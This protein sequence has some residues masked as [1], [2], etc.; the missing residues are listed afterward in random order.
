MVTT[1]RQGT[2]WTARLAV[3]IPRDGGDDITSDATRR[4]Q[5][6]SAISSVELVE[7]HGIEPALAATITHLEIRISTAK[8]ISKEDVRN[9]L[10]SAAGT[11]RVEHVGAV[12]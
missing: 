2:T 12:E 3:R 4:L 6:A 7:L 10:E 8:S 9:C 5:R 1:Q 11:E